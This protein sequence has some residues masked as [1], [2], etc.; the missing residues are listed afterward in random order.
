MDVPTRL[1][2]HAMVRRLIAADG[3]DIGAARELCRLVPVTGASVVELSA[4][5]SGGTGASGH[6]AGV[7]DVRLRDDEA[8]SLDARLGPS[9]LYAG[10]YKLWRSKRSIRIEQ[11]ADI[12]VAD[13]RVEAY[14]LVLRRGEPLRFEAHL[15]SSLSL[16]LGRLTFTF[17]RSVPRLLHDYGRSRSPSG[18][19]R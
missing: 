13:G 11:V 15:R 9:A 8:R 17:A 4:R 2:V 16:S 6:A 14:V 10:Q 18:D 1:E 5:T 3:G 7:G 12:E 19:S